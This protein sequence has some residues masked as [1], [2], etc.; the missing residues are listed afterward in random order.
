MAQRHHSR[1]ALAHV[2]WLGLHDDLLGRLCRCR[3]RHCRS[4]ERRVRGQHTKVPMPMGARRWHQRRNALYQLQRCEMQLFVGKNAAF[5]IFAKG[6]AD[7]RLGGVVVAL[8]ARL[9]GTG[10]LKPGL[11]VLGYG[12]VQQSALWVARVVEFGLC[13][14]WPTRARMHLRWACGGGHRAVPAWAGCLMMLGLYLASPGLLHPAQSPITPELIASNA[15][16][17]RA[18]CQFRHSLLPDA[19]WPAFRLGINRSWLG[20]IGFKTRQ[21]AR[22]NR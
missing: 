2:G 21:P 3:Q 22:R 7:I 20:C 1:C 17:T 8:A 5:Q 11:E 18:E 16:L 10:Q 19:A 4:P 6:L 14:R 13:I 9:A 15:H 12:L